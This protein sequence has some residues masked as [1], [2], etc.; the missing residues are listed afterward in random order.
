MTS[1]PIPL[2][3]SSYLCISSYTRKPFLIYDFA[4][5][6]FEFLY[7][8]GKFYFLFYQCT[9][10]LIWSGTCRWRSCLVSCRRRPWPPC[11]GW[12]SHPSCPRELRR[13]R[14]P[15]WR[16]ADGRSHQSRARSRDSPTRGEDSPGPRLCKNKITLKG[17]VSQDFYSR[18]VLGR[19]NI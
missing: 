15:P 12:V 4:P 2:T 16:P 7:I 8:W 5:D 14:P 11:G 10:T 9:D 13:G 17:R 18:R 6:P 19:R 3:N 1:H